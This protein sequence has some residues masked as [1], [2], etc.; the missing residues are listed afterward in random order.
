MD[1]AGPGAGFGLGDLAAAGKGPRTGLKVTSMLT[2]EDEVAVKWM[3]TIPCRW[4]GKDA[5][6]GI[7]KDGKG[8]T[9]RAICDWCGINEQAGIAFP[10]GKKIIELLGAPKDRWLGLD[11]HRPPP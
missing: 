8:S 3:G 5:R 9:Y 1:W 7:E 2:M 6:A 4:C 11:G 10:A